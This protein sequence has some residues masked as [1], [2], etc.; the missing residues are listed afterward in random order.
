MASIQP[1]QR[2]NQKLLKSTK[3]SIQSTDSVVVTSTDGLFTSY[4]DCQVSSQTTSTSFYY[5]QE[6]LYSNE[7][8]TCGEESIQG[9]DF[10]FAG[11]FIVSADCAI[12]IYTK[13]LKLVKK[14]PL[15]G[16]KFAFVQELWVFVT[17]DQV[18]CYSLDFSHLNT[19]KLDFTPIACSIGDELLLC[20]SDSIFALGL[21]NFALRVVGNLA[22]IS[23]QRES[24]SIAVCHLGTDHCCVL[25]Q[26]GFENNLSIFEL[27]YGTLQRRE[28][29][30]RPQNYLENK[31]QFDVCV[32]SSDTYG[33]II[34]FASAAVVKSELRV[35]FA[36]APYYCKKATLLSCLKKS[37]IANNSFFSTPIQVVP[38]TMKAKVIAKW[39]ADISTMTQIDERFM[40]ILLDSK[41]T[42]DEDSF[43][44]Q[45]LEYLDTKQKK[46]REL[47]ASLPKM[48]KMSLEKKWKSLLHIPIVQLPLDAAGRLCD[49]LFSSPKTFWPIPVIEYLINIGYINSATVSN[50]L[51]A[52]ILKRGDMALVQ[53]CVARVAD[54]SEQDFLEL[55]RYV[56]V[57]RDSD[58]VKI[59]DDSVARLHAGHPTEFSL[60]AGQHFY[61]NLVFRNFTGAA[62]VK[63]MTTSELQSIFAWISDCVTP[64]CENA[65]DGTGLH[66]AWWLWGTQ[67]TV[68]GEK[69][70]WVQRS[71]TPAYE[72]WATVISFLD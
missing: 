39:N 40:A 33:D 14:L 11:D 41:S 4:S 27:K 28:Q 23:D 38:K 12:A 32:S 52:S 34:A 25:S 57:P 50:G 7:T 16:V 21:D 58:H 47:G 35:E 26:K 48:P 49:R 1:V 68:I 53:T 42:P 10:Y 18:S 64:T 29:I 20:S 31:Y 17:D 54:N 63:Y 13:G 3:F 24:K 8:L 19:C 5:T 56:A 30:A 36:F 2:L 61:F 55:L 60:S 70:R 67:E 51:F 71:K 6:H 9:A 62:V 59:L 43:L 45:F 15:V 22:A 69:E 66:P 65:L 44:M 37:Q 46:L 72:N